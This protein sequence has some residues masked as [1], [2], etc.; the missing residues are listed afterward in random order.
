MIFYLINLIYYDKDL[1]DSNENLPNFIKIRKNFYGN[2]IYGVNTLDKLKYLIS[3][4]HKTGEYYFI[5]SSGRGAEE[6]FHSGYYENNRIMDFIIY[7]FNKEK[8]YQ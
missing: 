1:K 7:C 6:L 5:I 2:E 4:F 8:Y 3:L